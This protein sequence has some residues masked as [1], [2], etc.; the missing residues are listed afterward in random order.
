MPD[1]RV[2]IRCVNIRG[3]VFLLAEDVA[4]YMRELASSEETDVRERL[5]EAADN[6]APGASMVREVRDVAPDLTAA[7]RKALNG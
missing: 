2:H 6:L 5:N 7:M 1:S 3:R 4:K